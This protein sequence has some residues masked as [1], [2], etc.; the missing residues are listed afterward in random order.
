VFA[1]QVGYEGNHAATAIVGS[2]DFPQRLE[3]A[4]FHVVDDRGG[5]VFA[6]SLTPL[7]RMH[8]SRSDDWGA[9]YWLADFSALA[10][11]GRFR[12]RA[13]V[14]AQR[15][16]SHPFA[17]APGV[18]LKR[19]AELAYR[20]FYYQRC[21]GEVPGWHAPCH[22][23]DAR[24]PDGSHANLAGG[25]HDAGDYN[26]WMHAVGPSL[27]LYGMSSAYLGHRQFFDT[28]D[29]D[30][31][32]RA[33]LLDEIMWGADWLLRMRNP[34]SGGLYGSIATGWSYW[35]LA[36][37]ETD[38]IAGNADDRPALN[39]DQSVSR[40]AA[41]FAQ[42]ARIMPQDSRYLEAAVQLERYS[43]KEGLNPDRLLAN[44]AI[45]QAKGSV[46]YLDQARACAD[47]IAAGSPDGRQ[48]VALAALALFVEYAPEAKA[49][50]K[51]RVALLDSMTWLTERQAE[52]FRLA[53]GRSGLDRDMEQA[54]RFTQ[55]GHHMELTSNAWAAAACAKAL[56]Q[57][58]LLQVAYNELDWLLGLNPLDLCML[59]GA[60]SHHPARYHH[61]YSAIPGRRDGAVP[62]AIPNGIG[63]PTRFAGARV[64]DVDVPFMDEVNRDPSTDEPW[65]PYNGFLLCALGEMPGK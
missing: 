12:V 16:T 58:E 34:H 20:H 15:G 46:E 33:D 65:I 7:G 2:H 59:Q 50:P 40:A 6:G 41:A 27:A 44:L 45:W 13:E 60:G 25:W 4:R 51:Y 52:P 14:G 32:G 28:I 42:I 36:E 10:R 30:G 55:W 64:A 19:T 17:L 22:T 54:D 18:L 38:N 57:P 26:K 11:S 21:G 31:N 53:A 39:E 47:A 35:G 62:G 3:D 56:G 49:N 37:N 63:R 5:E 24:L 9:Y 48:G 23:D 8:E 61:R 29:R 43:R 1:N